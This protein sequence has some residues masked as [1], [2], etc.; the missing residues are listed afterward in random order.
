MIYNSNHGRLPAK[1][2]DDDTA[3]AKILSNTVA[4]MTDERKECRKFG[5]AKVMS[6]TMADT[7][8]LVLCRAS[9]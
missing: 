4:G 9:R 8:L 2:S 5:G 1:R 7:E 6:A 3:L